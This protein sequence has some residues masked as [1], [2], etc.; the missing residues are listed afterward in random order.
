MMQFSIDKYDAI[1]ASVR[2]GNNFIWVFV[3]RGTYEIVL[4]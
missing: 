2:I 1:V 4:K 3:P